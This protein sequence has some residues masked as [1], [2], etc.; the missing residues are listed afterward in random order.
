MATIRIGLSGYAYPEWQGE[1]LFYPP[2]LSKSKFLD[3]YSSV[4]PTVEGVGMFTRMPAES[5]AEKFLKACPPSFQLSPKMHQAVTHFK[6]LKP[7]S[8]PIVEDF[9]KPL[10]KLEEGEMMGSILIQLPPNFAAKTDVLS[11]FLEALPKQP[12]RRWAFEFRH[13]SWRSQDVERLLKSYEA[14][15]VCEETDDGEPHF[16]DTAPHCYFR[17]RKTEYSNDDL[18][19]WAQ[20]ISALRQAG[21]DCYVYFR[22]TDVESPWLWALSLMELMR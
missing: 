1:G 13:P 17:L 9:L 14:A 7:E 10:S 19:K 15:W 21:K 22:H 16:M 20:R 4:F 12:G 18:K 6:R 11:E 3:H 2:A 8:Y 5:T